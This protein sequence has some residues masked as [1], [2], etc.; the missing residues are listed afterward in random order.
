METSTTSNLPANIPGVPV[1]SSANRAAIDEACA[2]MDRQR[3]EL[4]QKFGEVELVVE[5]LREVREP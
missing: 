1:I 4:K 3:E 2:R 5:V